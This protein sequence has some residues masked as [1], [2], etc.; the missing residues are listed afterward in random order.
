MKVSID[1]AQEAIQL[2]REQLGTSQQG[3]PEHLLRAVVDGRLVFEEENEKFTYILR[4]PIELENG[5]SVTELTIQEPTAEQLKQSY[6]T[7]SNEMEQTLR[8]LS[9][10]TGRPLGLL[11]RIRQ[12][13]LIVIGEVLSFFA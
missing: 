10:I 11:Q 5:E 9:A 13:D 3:Y 8:L 4:K 1:E 12:R 2:W 7:G 6:K